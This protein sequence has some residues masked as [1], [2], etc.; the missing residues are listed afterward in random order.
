MIKKIT[1]KVD[2]ITEK[3][4]TL[5]IVRYN[6]Q[7][8][9]MLFT[10]LSLLINII[11]ALYNG[12]LGIVYGS[13]WFVTMFAY[14]LLLSVMRFGAVICSRKKS[15]NKGSQKFVV[16]FTGIMLVLLSLVLA[17]VNYYVS[18]KNTAVKQDKIIM[19]S[20]AAFTFYKV[21]VAIVNFV[22]TSKRNVLLEKTVRNIS[23]ADALV[24]V[25]SLQ[26]SMLV[27]FN[28]MTQ[29]EIKLMNILTGTGVFIIVFL[30]GV[31]MICG[32]FSKSKKKI[33]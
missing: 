10:L 28:G 26:R 32:F 27:S 31:A 11:Y 6:K 8:R 1:E 18:Q 33:T 20:I 25:Y 22:K 15:K 4:R 16:R 14:Y 29:G 9:L 30:L 3:N 5:S 24:S 17:G 13:F 7:K 23:V 21:T 12:V 19:I 2:S